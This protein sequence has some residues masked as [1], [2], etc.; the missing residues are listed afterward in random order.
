MQRSPQPC[1][2]RVAHCAVALGVIALLAPAG[3]ASAQTD[4]PWPDRAENLKVLP[5]DFPK[6]NLRAVMTGFTRA[7]GVRC[8]HCHAGEKGAKL[9]EIDFVSDDNPNKNTARAMLEML[10]DINES[11]KEIDPTGPERVNMWCHTCHH[12]TP[13]PMR[14]DEALLESY[15]SGGGDSLTTKYTQLH[16]RYFGR[17]AYDFGE[18]TLNGLGYRFLGEE[19]I[20]TAVRVFQLNVDKYPESANVWDSLAESYVAIGDTEQAIA[21]YR[22]SLEL[23]PEGEHAR[24]K[25]TELEAQ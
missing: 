15:T 8:T 10:G 7:L 3:I 4:F 20:E 21:N 13:R 16:D 2:R 25:L 24:E 14:L 22:K 6:E 12:G 11:L 17:G 9:S 23:D 19:D 5:E 18:H 1:R